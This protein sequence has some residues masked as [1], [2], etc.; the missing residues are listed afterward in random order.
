MSDIVDNKVEAIVLQ[1]TAVMNQLSGEPVNARAASPLSHANLL[2]SNRGLDNKNIS[3]VEK[4]FLGHLVLR[5]DATDVSFNVAI[6]NTLACELPTTLQC[7][8]ND[9]LSIRWISP[10]EWLI[11]C[12]GNKAYELE[13]ILR[14]ALEGHYSICNVSGGQTLLVLSG[15]HARDVL[16]KSTSYDVADCHFPVGKVVTTAFS[17]SQAVICR[18]DEDVWEL[19]IRRSFSDYI[20]RWLQDA[21]LEFNK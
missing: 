5:G 9:D 1:K 20:W 8:Y 11:V 10:D 2:E 14:K 7:V 17:K 15:R 6:Q 19:I 21:C 16:M 3:L 12:A 13:T 4:K 18:K